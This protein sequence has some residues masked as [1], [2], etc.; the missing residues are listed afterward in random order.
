MPGGASEQW[1]E[2]GDRVLVRR[3]ESL[4]LNVGLVL[5]D[6][7]CLVI[8][9]RSSEVEGRELAAAVRRVTPHPWVVVDTHAHHDHCFGNIV[10]RPAEIWAHR[11]CAAVLAEYG[12]VSR[13]VVAG[14]LRGMDLPDYAADVEATRIDPPDRLFD[15]AADLDVGGRRVALRYLGRGHTD[16]DLV[17][18]VPDAG[19]LFAGDLLEEGSPPWFGDSFPLEW[20]DTVAAL[21]ALVTGP[22]VPGHGAVVDA[23][24]VAH[25]HADLV[26][27]AAAA[28]AAYAAGQPVE[29]AIGDLPFPAEFARDA[30]ERAYR[31]LRGEPAYDPAAEVLRRALRAQ[32]EQQAPT[33]GST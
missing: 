33:A 20:P 15:T 6:G 14:A 29:A 3:H 28:R 5:G 16:S 2:V 12:E 25:Q 26:R 13:Q 21:A 24:F 22:V 11:R 18:L 27:T 19:V 1:R 9:T 31:Q 7:A 4:D 30:L 10:F 23:G 32:H 17:A 8:D